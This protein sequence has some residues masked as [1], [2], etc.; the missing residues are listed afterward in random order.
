MTWP[1]A[2]NHV[3]V[4]ADV[5][6]SAGLVALVALAVFIGA[7]KIA[8][9]IDPRS[10]EEPLTPLVVAV[11]RLISGFVAF[12]AIIGFFAGGLPLG[13]S[14]LLR[15]V[16]AAMSAHAWRSGPAVPTAVAA[17]SARVEMSCA[18]K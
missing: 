9:F 8:Y 7:Q 2:D 15:C 4:A 12:F 3:L 14:G 16:V 10:R 13:G 17:A 6:W 5:S 18:S 1:S 11:F